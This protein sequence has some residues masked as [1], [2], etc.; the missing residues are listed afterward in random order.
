M[1]LRICAVLAV[2]WV[3]WMERNKR[4]FLEARGEDVDQLWDRVCYWA[5]LGVGLFRV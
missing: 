1:V 4:I 3:V 5:S 2:F